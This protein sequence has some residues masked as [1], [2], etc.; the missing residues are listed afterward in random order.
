MRCSR[1]IRTVVATVACLLALMLNGCGGGSKTACMMLDASAST[2]FARVEYL[3]Q[4]RSD[5]ERA[6]SGGGDVAVVV[7][8]GNAL[9]ES[10]VMH[11][12]FDG[13][14][15]TER[16]A[17]RSADVASFTDEVRTA[18]DQA[19]AGATNP[20]RGSG[21]I[22]GIALFG[23]QG[24]GSITALS[25]GIENSG[26]MNVATND[27]LSPTGRKALLDRL[28]AQERVPDLHGVTLSFPFGGYAPQ[29]SKLSADRMNALPAFWEAYAARTGANLRWER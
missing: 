27:I 16:A 22:A 13:L 9:I 19:S 20:T 8:N 10:D 3:R 28:A 25:D 4:F 5:L 23:H 18:V 14:Q 2:D 17:Q 7:A 11:H 29:G 6:A 1:S 12:S 15:G 26:D 21:V 24:C